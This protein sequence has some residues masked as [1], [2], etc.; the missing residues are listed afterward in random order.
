[1]VSA[2]VD[3]QDPSR[4]ILTATTTLYLQKVALAAL[5]EE[6]E[7]AIRSQARKDLLENPQVKKLIAEAATQLLLKMLNAAPTV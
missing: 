5:S 4:I 6:V 7:V 3:P 2:L 1:M